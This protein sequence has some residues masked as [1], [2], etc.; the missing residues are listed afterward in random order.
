MKR[1][2]ISTFGLLFLVATHAPAE[3]QQLAFPGAEGFGRHALG[4]R[5]GAVH[6]VTT[7]NDSGPGSLRTCVEASGARTCVFRVGGTI[8]LA[9]L[10]QPTSGRLTIAGQTAPGG[11]IQLQLSSSHTK[12]L[13][14][15]Q[16]PD[17]VIRNVRLR[18]GATLLSAAPAGTC[19]GDGVAVLSGANRVILDRVSIGFATDENVDIY[20]AKNV[21]I[22]NSIIAYGLRYS[23]DADTLQNP[24]QHHSMGVLIGGSG[25]NNLSLLNNFLAFNL[26]RNPGIQGGLN[27][28]C[29][30]VVY[31][32]TANPITVAGGTVNVIGNRFDPRPQNNYTYVIQTSGSGRVHASGNV[33]PVPIFRSGSAQRATPYST[34][35]CVGKVPVSPAQVGPT[36][37]DGLDALAVAHAGDGTGNLIDDPAEVG[38]WPELAD[39]TPYPDVDLDGMDDE[40]EA[41]NGITSGTLDHDSDGFTNL[42]EFLAS[43]LPT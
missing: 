13:L 14:R 38:G 16:V 34:P 24:S 27:E 26:N 31:G 43:L 10:L 20:Q 42:E 2:M 4:G 19:C 25:V 41:A 7:L 1:H 32:A 3:A 22:Q 23:T 35:S 36:P 15:I 39:G 21:T 6:H 8:T 33:T 40:W 17:V 5:G 18:R 11:G 30:N 28:V 12:Q 37:R 29:G 9:T